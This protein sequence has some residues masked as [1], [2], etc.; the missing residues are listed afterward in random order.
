M[1]NKY[2]NL[3]GT[4]KIKDEYKKINIGFDKVEE[5]LVNIIVTPAEGVSEQEIIQARKGKATLNDRLNETDTNINTV[6]NNL[7]SRIDNIIATPTTVSEQEIIDARQGKASL[8]ANL[9]AIKEDLGQ[10]KLDYIEQNLSD[11]M[12]IIE[13][14]NG[15]KSEFDYENKKFIQRTKVFRLKPE[16]IVNV[17]EGET[18]VYARTRVLDNFNPRENQ[19]EQVILDGYESTL[20]TGA[21]TIE[22]IGKFAVR[23]DS[24]IAVYFPLGTT[25]EEIRAELDGTLLVY[26][27][28]EVQEI[29]LPEK[30]SSNANEI[31]RLSSKYSELNM[32]FDEFFSMI[33][34][35]DEIWEVAE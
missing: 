11:E 33:T 30:M 6:N 26:Q 17:I 21:D 1:A 18:L 16:D 25:L 13:L 9:T 32:Q 5:D 15:V 34:D 10:H 35:E 23:H 31:L 24:R 4:K 7:N 2:C 20:T 8:G 29:P 19:R 28:A 14:P 22:N 12:V 27:L 3:D